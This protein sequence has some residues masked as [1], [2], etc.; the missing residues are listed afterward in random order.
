M[1]NHLES[2][3]NRSLFLMVAM[4]LSTPCVAQNTP[5]VQARN[6]SDLSGKFSIEAT[7]D[8]NKDGLVTLRKGSGETIV[9]TTGRLSKPDQAYV[10]AFDA[11]V[12]S[13]SQVAEVQALMEQIPT[14]PATAI[15][16]LE[17]LHRKTEGV[18]PGLVCG[19]FLASDGGPQKSSD[20]ERYLTQ[21][22]NRLRAIREHFPEQHPNTFI[23]A[24][25]NL[26][27]LSLRS[28]SV[29]K[30]VALLEEAAKVDPSKPFEVYHNAALI[31]NVAESNKLLFKSS[32]ANLRRLAGIMPTTLP[33]LPGIT[34]PDRFLY[35]FN[36]D[37]ANP[38]TVTALPKSR[39]D[40]FRALRLW[41]ELNCY[42]C[43]GSGRRDCPTCVR[44]VVLVP[45]TDPVSYEPATGRTTNIVSSQKVP[46][47]HCNAQ[48]FFRCRDCTNGRVA[49]D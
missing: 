24:L 16:K 49:F 19:G 48:G 8:S 5:L 18:I 25:N 46:C 33:T 7:L 34:A 22:V 23:S 44:G 28:R 3:C 30:A 13:E 38:P 26:A 36:F 29:A 12:I 6:W 14:T 27:V 35:S 20:A 21:T 4:Y 1:Q 47:P 41:P 42:S 9:I 11:L 17:E 37:Q 40:A 39:Q 15:E 10:G 43:S 45:R 2:I 32:S 31:A